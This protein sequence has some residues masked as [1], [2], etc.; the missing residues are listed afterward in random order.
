MAVN[1]RCG[2]MISKTKGK[3]Y[4]LKKDKKIDEVRVKCKLNIAITRIAYPYA[5]PNILAEFIA[6]QSKNHVIT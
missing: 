1:L 2:P 4:L 3:V 5:C 6:G